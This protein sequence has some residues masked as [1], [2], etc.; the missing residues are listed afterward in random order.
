MEVDP[1][2]YA[3]FVSGLIAWHGR[4]EHSVILALSRCTQNRRRLR[5][6]TARHSPITS[7]DRRTAPGSSPG[8]F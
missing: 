1:A 4:T 7:A 8:R 3:E 2:V 5:A 6:A